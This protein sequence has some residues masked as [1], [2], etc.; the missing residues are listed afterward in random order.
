MIKD[1]RIGMKVM[2]NIYKGDGIYKEEIGEI[3]GIAEA[4]GSLAIAF[5]NF[6]GHT[7]DGLI[8]EGNGIW[9]HPKNENLIEIR[10]FNSLA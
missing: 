6:R 2:C 4:T 1:P 5:Q 9:I 3:V 10:R 8:P 7:C